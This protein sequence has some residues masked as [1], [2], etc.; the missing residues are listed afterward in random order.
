MC[1]WEGLC[2]FSFSCVLIEIFDCSWR[3]SSWSSTWRRTGAPSLRSSDLLKLQIRS[4]GHIWSGHT[5]VFVLTIGV[6]SPPPGQSCHQRAAAR[7]AA[8][9]HQQSSLQ[10]RVRHLSHRALGLARGVATAIHAADG[11]AGQRRRQCRARGHEGPHRYGVK[12]TG[13][14]THM[15]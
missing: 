5:R 9:G 14:Q 3:L 12:Q 7:R 2:L 10:R 6:P 4:A 11:D 1:S 13:T 15:Q 8:G